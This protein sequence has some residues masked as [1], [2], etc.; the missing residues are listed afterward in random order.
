VDKNDVPGSSDLLLRLNECEN[1]WKEDAK[2]KGFFAKAQSLLGENKT[3]LLKISDYSTT[4]VT[5]GDTE[6]TGNWYNLVRCSGSSFKAAGDGGSFG[7]GKNA[8]FAASAL[9]TVFYSTFNQKKE[10]IF[11]GV[12]RLVT[13][14]SPAGDGIAQPTGYCGMPNGASVRVFTEIPELLRRT[15]QGTDILIYGYLGGQNWQNDIVYSVLENFWPAISLGDLVVKVADVEINKATL[16][17]L[18]KQYSDAGELGASFY[19][20]AFASPKSRSF[21]GQLGHFGEVKLWLLVSD[22]TFPN[23][24]AMARKPGMVVFTRAFR[25]ILRF[26]GFFQCSKDEGNKRLR[27]ME[28]PAHDYWDPDR[29]EKG[30]NRKA[31]KELY[32]WIRSCIRELAPPLESKIIAIPDLYRYLPDDGDAED[33]MPFGEPSAEPGAPV[34]ESFKELPVTEPLKPRPIVPKKAVNVPQGDE[35][36]IGGPDKNGEQNGEKG[37]KKPGQGPEGKNEHPEERLVAATFRSYL[38]D[39]TTNTYLVAVKP[40]EDCLKTELRVRAVGDDSRAEAI[41]IAEAMLFPG[42]SPLSIG[43]PNIIKGIALTAGKPF[44]LK[45]RVS[46]KLRYALEVAAYAV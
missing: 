45:L 37:G 6:R 3:P 13:H 34:Q 15:A 28:P 24:V 25:S 20:N 40:K 4:G 22:S 44:S 21:T 38:L 7:I 33:T 31:E 9:R 10:H 30:A 32:D 12:A 23:K 43:Q 27:D 14:E 5:G 46:D 29:P 18:V 41:T 42:N 8:P 11:Q 35:E 17:I 16:P 39:G 2:A 19:F 36:D 26:S 1:Y